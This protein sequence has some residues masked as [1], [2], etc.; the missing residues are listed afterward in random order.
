MTV[1]V[2][3]L[4]EEVGLFGA[5]SGT[6]VNFVVF[7]VGTGIDVEN[8]SR[9]KFDWYER[10][11]IVQV[12]LHRAPSELDVGGMQLDAVVGTAGPSEPREEKAALC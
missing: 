5:A 11:M 2:E 10:V 7:Y 1:D 8:I 6:A 3:K 12:T 4:L 9:Q